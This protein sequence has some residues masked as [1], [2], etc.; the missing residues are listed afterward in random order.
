MTSEDARMLRD[1]GQTTISGSER[2]PSLHKV[3]DAVSSLSIG[4]KINLFLLGV[5]VL[6]PLAG[7]DVP[8]VVKI[9]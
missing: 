6:P 2:P 4:V 7:G 3:L 8:L 9:A 5:G 1:T